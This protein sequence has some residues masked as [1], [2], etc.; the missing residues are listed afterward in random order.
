LVDG[1]IRTFEKAIRTEMEALQAAHGSFEIPLAS[2][3]PEPAPENAEE[4]RYRFTCAATNDTLVAGAECTLAYEGGE[5]LVTLVAVADAAVTVRCGRELPLGS[6]TYTLVVYPWFL[7]QRLIQ[8]LKSMPADASFNVD[9]AL[10]AFGKRPVTVREEPLLLAH[11][12]LNPSQRRAVATAVQSDVAFIWGPP[13]TGK[14]R[15]LGHVVAELV[16]R[17]QRLLITST[18]HAAVDQALAKLHAMPELG[19]AFERG[20]IVRYGRT[21][22]ETYGASVREV[23]SRRG[24]TLAEDYAAAQTELRR[25]DQAAYRCRELLPR[26]ENAESDQLDLFGES[27]GPSVATWELEGVIEPAERPA[28]AAAHP[29][30]QAAI[31][32]AASGK[33][34]AGIEAVR[35]QLER[36]RRDQRN[37]EER[38]VREAGVLLS[39]MSSTYAGT[40]LVDLRFDTVILEEA[41]MAVLPAL[42][43]CA[44]LASRKVVLVGDPRQLPAI[45]HSQDSYVYRA[46][47][48]PIFD[49]SREACEHVTVMLDTQYRM[50][51]VIGRLVSSLFYDGNLRSDPSM[52]DRASVSDLPPFPGAPLVLVDTVGRTQCKRAGTS[53]SRWNPLSAALCADLTDAAHNG[54]IESVAII[55]PYVAQARAIRDLLRERAMEDGFAE[56]STVHRFQ[57]NERHL[58]ILDTVDAAPMAP[59]V[60]LTGRRASWNLLNVSLSRAQGKL[61]IVADV[62][63]YQ[64]LATNGALAASLSRMAGTA[65][66]YT[67]DEARRLLTGSGRTLPPTEAE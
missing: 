17:G 5:A 14:T 56:C 43:Y 3:Q 57:G 9:A 8:M 13:G 36:I 39:T 58:V 19:E 24:E 44:G 65:A 21:E 38:V 7:Y 46:M 18:T 42:F 11:E 40:G 45:L 15:T 61:V 51:P 29:R 63:Y 10:R 20:S 41:A 23:V 60:L 2:P 33:A 6:A 50:H 55:T 28:F 52:A 1:F 22:S 59:G 34:Q 62:A 67:M 35:A 64:E 26:Y 54:G 48:R 32:E 25:H 49:V 27:S 37:L 31:L 66:V 30:E 16:A 47:G 53:F 12:E 4:I